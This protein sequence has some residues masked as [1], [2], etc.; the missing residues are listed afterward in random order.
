[1]E[2]NMMYKY[3]TN[4]KNKL[5]TCHPVLHDIANEAIATSPY[6]ITI[7]HG[8]RGMDLQN[9]LYAKG[10]S[11]L[12]FPFSRHNKTDDPHVIDPHRLSDALDFAPYVNGINWED[13]HIFSVIAGCFFAAA[14]RMGHV[15]RWGGDWD[16]DGSTKDQTFMDWGHLEIVWSTS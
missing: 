10:K 9:Q 1:M 4:S 3:S 12:Q 7:I 16:M 13:S 11:K 8:W 5:D 15:L 2:W 14:I 6:D